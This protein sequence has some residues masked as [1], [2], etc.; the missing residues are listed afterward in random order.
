[1]FH[2]LASRSHF[3]RAF[4]AAQ[5]HDPTTYRALHRGDHPD[6]PP[7]QEASPLGKLIGR[8]VI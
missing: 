7:T 3:S 6:A 2:S 4:S 8:E 1:V 5:K